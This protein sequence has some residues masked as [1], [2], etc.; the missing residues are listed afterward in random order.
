MS[1]TCA[2]APEKLLPSIADITESGLYAPLP[3][4]AECFE[5]RVVK[6]PAGLAAGASPR[7]FT[8]R[9]TPEWGSVDGKG[10]IDVLP[11]WNDP[12]AQ[13]PRAE[14]ISGHPR[15]LDAAYYEYAE[16]DPE[17]FRLS[18]TDH[19]DPVTKVPVP[20]WV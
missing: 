8:F 6:I 10:R 5:N 15:V 11:P 3:A 9:T 7:E 13:V 1:S 12:N 4:D 17:L 20:F 16:K 18:D 19:L 2:E 14:L